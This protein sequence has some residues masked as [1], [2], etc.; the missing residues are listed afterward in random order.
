MSGADLTG[1]NDGHALTAI[2]ATIRDGVFL[3]D[4][5]TARGQIQL[6]HAYIGGQL[7]MSGA[8]LIALED[9][10]ALEA[11]NATIEGGAFL[12]DGFTAD[13]RIGLADTTMRSLTL[14]GESCR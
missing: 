2:G 4:G 6:L 11:E 5:F 12:D 7:G 3:S 9:G 8:H 1:D 13:G 10:D 14:P